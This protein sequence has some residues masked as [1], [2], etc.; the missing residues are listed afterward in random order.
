MKKSDKKC[1]PFLDRTGISFNADA[2]PYVPSSFEL[3]EYCRKH[4]HKK[5]PFFL[6]LHV[7][8]FLNSNLF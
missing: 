2:E 7:W 8:T 3:R 6:N 4:E 5:C 1:C